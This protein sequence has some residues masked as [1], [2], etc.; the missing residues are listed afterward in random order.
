[1][2]FDVLECHQPNRDGIVK[3]MYRADFCGLQGLS[4]GARVS[5]DYYYGRRCGQ[6]A[7]VALYKSV[8]DNSFSRRWHIA[9]G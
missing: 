4:K 2:M 6:R 1:M 7:A 5:D 8:D 9:R 3:M